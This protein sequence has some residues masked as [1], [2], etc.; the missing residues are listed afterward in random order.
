[1][2]IVI[3]IGRSVNRLVRGGFSSKPKY[4]STYYLIITFFF[5]FVFILILNGCTS[6]TTVCQPSHS[7]GKLIF[8]LYYAKRFGFRASLFSFRLEGKKKL[9]R[10]IKMVRFVRAVPFTVC[11]I[12]TRRYLT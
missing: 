2:K 11:G 1:M 3:C 4:D 5:S 9:F 12:S 6:A 7:P 8:K 10:L